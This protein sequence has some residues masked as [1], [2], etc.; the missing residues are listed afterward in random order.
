MLL[1]LRFHSLCW[2]RMGCVSAPHGNSYCW[3]MQDNFSIH[4]SDASDEIEGITEG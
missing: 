1:L 4:V 3:N 2:A